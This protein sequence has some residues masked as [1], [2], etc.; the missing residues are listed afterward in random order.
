MI[1]GRSSVDALLYA[2]R[3]MPGHEK[4]FSTSTVPVITFANERPMT[5]MIEGIAARRMCRSKTTREGMPFE[6]AART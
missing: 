2:Y 6:R 1:A 4:I 3:P 5:V